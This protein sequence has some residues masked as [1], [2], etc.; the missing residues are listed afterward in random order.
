MLIGTA[1]M[2]DDAFITLRVVDNF[3]N[4][5]GLR[6]NVLE[7]V[8]AFTHPLWMFFLTPFYA[9]TREPFLTVMLLSVAVSLSALWVLAARIASR[10][11]WGA[12]LILAYMASTALCDFSTSGLET[13]LTF[14][15]IA[16]FVWQSGKGSLIGAPII[17]GLLFFNRLDLIVLL[18]PA[19]FYLFLQAKGKRR[20]HVIGASL[21]PAAGWMLFSLVYYGAPFPNTAYAKLGTGLDTGVLIVRGLQYTQDFILADPLLALLIVAAVFL[22]LRSKQ[23]LAKSLGIGMI[24]Y[25]A[26][27][28]KIGGDF[29]S[30]RFFA[31]MG[32]LALCILAREPL[33]PLLAKWWKPIGFAGVTALAALLGLRM[34]EG[35]LS[36]L[37]IPADGIIEERL[38]YYAGTGLLPVLKSRIETGDVPLTQWVQRGRELREI[39][40]R[41]NA[42]I[43]VASGTI[44]MRGYFGGPQVHLIDELALT[45]A[46]LARLPAIPHSRVGHYQ[47]QLP[48]GY[49]ETSVT[50]H[51][52]TGDAPL[53]PLLDDVTLAT[54]AP[55]TAQGR[56]D[57][58]W[59][60]LS[61]HY[62]W[63]YDKRTN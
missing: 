41:Q 8:Q 3:V 50:V 19:L 54:R 30:G 47:R 6:F 51:P 14:L 23:W 32:F 5:N 11:E 60:L 12:L 2:G 10:L 57:A 9:L 25:F 48:A 44:G 28:L 18:A 34:T 39:A 27:I 46:F 33:P 7:R 59:R 56:W 55:L 62:R 37:A 15:L 20:L 22:A 40:A 1:W 58:I 16:L 21:A 63:V 4:G 36:S 38:F 17:A 31:P 13:P 24:L 49:A 26:Y 42:P 43:V 53:Q 45:D 35:P 29:M 52:V 61:G